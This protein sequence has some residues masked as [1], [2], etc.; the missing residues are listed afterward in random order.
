MKNRKIRILHV[1][2]TY[3]PETRGGI[4]EAIRQ[5][6]LNTSLQGGVICRVFTLSPHPS[7]PHIIRPEGEVF[8]VQTTAE[9]ASC[10]VSV[11][12][13][14]EF[15]KQVSWADIIHYHFPWP[16]ADMLHLFNHVKKPS[17]I[18][19]H[20]D[21]VRQKALLKVYTPLMNW[22]LRQMR[23][24]VATSPNYFATSTILGKFAEKTKV[25]PLAISRESYP[26]INKSLIRKQAR[27]VGEGFF[28]FVGVLRYYKGLHILID[29]VVGTNFKVVIVGAGPIEEELKQR[30]EDKGVTDNIIFRGQVSNEEKMAL[31]QLSCSMVFPSHLRSEAFGMT[32]LEGAMFGKPLISTEIGTGT[33]YVNIHNKTGL[34][35]VPSNAKELRDAMA[36]LHSHPH[37][38]KK[39]GQRAKVR[40]EELFSGEN[41]GKA[42]MDIY[43]ELVE[44]P[45]NQ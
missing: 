18:T 10:T 22:F 35:V 24:I 13:L 33:S 3:F 6:C 21:V 31:I 4:E 39:M 2:R 34:V 5:I 38:A 15:R 28:L 37:E 26:V 12:G 11:R 14:F 8:R 29:A 45:L 40:Y 25:I 17:L 43:Q 41:M 7:P 20:S 19:Y 1:C 16:F 32:L 42:Y 9:I 27:E 30:A 36:Y 23:Y 44:D